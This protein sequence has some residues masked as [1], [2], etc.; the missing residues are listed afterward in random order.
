MEE[1]DD[2][3]QP[4]LAE[5]PKQS[6]NMP[7]WRQAVMPAAALTLLTSCVIAIDVRNPIEAL[8][9]LMVTVPITFLFWW[10]ICTFFLWLWE[11]FF[12]VNR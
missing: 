6:P 9:N 5:I 8:G 11:A 3:S 7:L 12:E 10:L 1:L 4:N 2:R